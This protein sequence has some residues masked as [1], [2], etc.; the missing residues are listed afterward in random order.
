MD[1][2]KTLRDIIIEKM[3]G[4]A[5]ELKPC[6]FCGSKP[7][8]MKKDFFN[9]LQEDAS[10]GTACITLECGVC[11]LTFYDHTLDEHDYYIRAFLI[12]EKWNRRIEKC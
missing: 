7:T 3:K 11:N 9:E 8:L 4:G 2:N 1:A 10:D 12:V 6:P 5:Y